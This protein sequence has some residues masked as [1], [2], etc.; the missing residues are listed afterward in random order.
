M[1]W[2]TRSIARRR[3][4]SP[5]WPSAPSWGRARRRSSPASAPSPRCSS[6]RA[7]PSPSKTS[8]ARCAISFARADTIAGSMNPAIR[9]LL[10]ALGVLNALVFAGSAGFYVLGHGRW[11]FGDCIYMTVIT[12]S[13]VGF[14]EL[15]H[16]RE[17]PGARALT[18]V[19]I[20]S[21]VGALAYV[22]G[23]LT[24]LLVEGALGQAFRRN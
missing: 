19:L 6:A 4:A 7:S 24:A 18:I 17:V 11:A 20:V 5:R 9:R 16:M 12:L 21:G 1:P 15:S 8:A 3:S 2:A 13:T 10:L 14:G 22:Q 23:N